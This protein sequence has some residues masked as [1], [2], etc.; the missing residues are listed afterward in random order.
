VIATEL[1][2][3][4][5]MLIF[6]ILREN[7]ENVEKASTSGNNYMLVWIMWTPE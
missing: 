3:F 6:A 2:K 5:K 4:G 7:L 1:Q